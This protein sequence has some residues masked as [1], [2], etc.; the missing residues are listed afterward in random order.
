MS[1][2]IRIEDIKIPPNRR[3][4]PGDVDVLRESIRENGLLNPVTVRPVGHGTYVLV[5]GQR[6]LRAC[7]QLAWTEIDAT[8]LA[9]TDDVHCRLAEIDENLVRRKLT[10]LEEGELFE[11]RRQIYETL[12]PETKQHVAGGLARQG[13]QQAT[14][15]RLLKRPRRKSTGPPDTCSA[16]PESVG[17]RRK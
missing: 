6:R 4:D 7:R 3:I 11:E 13:G 14:I 9:N 16:P 15:R 12:H 10:A 8:V 2:K 5:A 1:I 17:F